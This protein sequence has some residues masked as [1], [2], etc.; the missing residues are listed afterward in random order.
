MDYQNLKNKSIALH[1]THARRHLFVKPFAHLAM[2]YIL[3]IKK[4]LLFSPYIIVNIVSFGLYI[5]NLSAAVHEFRAILT[6]S[7]TDI[8]FVINTKQKPAAILLL[9]CVN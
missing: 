6:L 9:N 5:D 1:F 7:I 2:C 3:Y 4:R 8:V